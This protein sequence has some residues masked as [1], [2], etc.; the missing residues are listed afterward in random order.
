MGSHL[1]FMMITGEIEA[2][3]DATNDEAPVN[4]NLDQQAEQ[5]PP[6]PPPL[7]PVRRSTIER[8]PSTRYHPYEY[9]M[10]TD[11][12][13]PESYQEVM[14]HEWLKAMQ[15]ELKSLHEN[16]TYELVKLLNKQ[17]LSR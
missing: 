9:V 16:H 14:A 2:Q 10:L 12:G 7:A 13:E 4:E 6:A 11:V 8:R 5:I 3:D 1:Q 15:E 17:R